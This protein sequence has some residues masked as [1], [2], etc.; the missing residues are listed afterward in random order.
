MCLIF[1]IITCVWYVE[2]VV[3]KENL[4]NIIIN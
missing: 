2:D 4:H 1:I 3:T